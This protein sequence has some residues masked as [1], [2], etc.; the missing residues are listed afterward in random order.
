M[1]NGRSTTSYRDNQMTNLN[2]DTAFNLLINGKSVIGE[3]H[4]FDVINPA[5]GKAIAVCNSAS[6]KQVD[7]AIS[8]AKQAWNTWRY[9]DEITRKSILARIA[10][11]IE[12]HSHELAELIV[13]EQG[14]PLALAQVEVAGAI[15]WTRY[16]ANIDIPVEIITDD[17][18]KRIEVH[19]R[20]MGV[21][22]SIT[23]WNW[24]LMIAVWHIMPA[25]RAGNVVI[26]KP[27]EYTPLATVKLCELIQQEVPAGVISV[28]TG[29]A[30][31][32]AAL[33]EHTDIAK[34]V[35]TGST[36]TG[37]RIMENAAA[38]LKHVTLELGGNDAGI[39][40]PDTNLD[41]VASPIFNAAFLNMGQTCAALKR[42]YVHESQYDALAH[43]LA[44]LA[45][46]QIVGD[47]LNATTTFGPVQNL[48]QYKKVKQYIVSACEQGAK[49]LG[50]S[51][52]VPEQGYFIAPVILIDVNEQSAVVQEEQFGP[53]LPILKYQNIE[54]VIA[55]VNQNQYGLGGSIWT[56]NDEEALKYIDRLE[57]GTAWINTHGEVLPH[58][59]F[60]G[61]KYSGLGSEF[62]LSGLLEN[63]IKQVI[64][65]HK[66]DRSIDI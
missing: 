64:H 5:N 18:I 17:E 26:S 28:L 30:E 43:K 41:R 44:N 4:S 52:I 55:Q 38:T 2:L 31:V 27:S 53:V 36:A 29:S 21:I 42:L 45:E 20:A 19:H 35:F 60:G 50:G 47:G 32:G 3:A 14:K 66:N 39:V 49:L 23:P 13:Q 58:V 37:Q 6:K 61:W 10:D 59:P 33:C 34:I 57:C 9:L 12:Q 1:I 16:Y 7:L 15:A 8:S 65:Y 48:Q 40:L 63:T 11:R 24:P 51:Q 46:Q 25:L 22:V 62:G 56:S 54:D